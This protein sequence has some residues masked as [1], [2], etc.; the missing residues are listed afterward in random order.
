MPGAELGFDDG[1]RVAV[2]AALGEIGDDIGL[3]QGPRGLQRQQFGVAGTSADAD[4][5]AFG[6]RVHRPGLASELSAAA[7]M[8][9]PPSR[10]RTMA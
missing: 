3:G 2:V 4:E 5:T 8:A 6:K 10:P 7:V 9:L 1:A